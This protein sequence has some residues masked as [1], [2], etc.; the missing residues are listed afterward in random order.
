[1]YQVDA[2]S[3][4]VFGGNPAAVVPLETFLPDALMQAGQTVEVDLCGHATLAAAHVVF[5]H[6]QH[7]G[8]TV[9]FQS[10]SGA[11][12]VKQAG[13]WLYLD[14]PADRLQSV[15][16]E[17]PIFPT[18]STAI[19]SPI[20]ALYR[21]RDDF[22]VVLESEAAVAALSPDFVA[23]GAVPCRGVI[24]TATGEGE[25]CD[26]VSRFFAPRCGIPEDPVT[27]SAHTSLVPHWHAVTGRTE[28]TARQLSK[29]GGELRC[30]WMGERTE[31]GGQAR[32]F[33]VAEIAVP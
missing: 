32:T 17:N 12:S 7:P 4:S 16:P 21:G 18:I 15:E 22:L 10:R 28:F 14:F 20:K 29:R 3:P 24:V 30:R 19:G 5:Q 9:S 8:H 6:L 27:G 1:M 33:L 13:D 31:I 11:L 2:F 25:A 23:L 26:F